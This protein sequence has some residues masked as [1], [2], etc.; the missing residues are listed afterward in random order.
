MLQ[1]PPGLFFTEATDLV[2]PQRSHICS[3]G[4]IKDLHDVTSRTSVYT[5]FP[6]TVFLQVYIAEVMPNMATSQFSFFL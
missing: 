5:Y 3:N 4:G 1:K 6:Y 2:A